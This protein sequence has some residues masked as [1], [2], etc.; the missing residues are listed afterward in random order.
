MATFKELVRFLDAV[1][2]R[3]LPRVNIDT[4]RAIATPDISN[5][6]VFRCSGSVISITNFL[7]GFDGQTIKIRGDGNTT[8]TNN[9][10]IVT[11]TAANKLLANGKVYY[12]TYFSDTK[13]WYEKE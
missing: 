9:A 13:K 1:D 4:F 2:F 8:I 11:N 5:R 3:I 12:Y 7:G 10:N 6:E